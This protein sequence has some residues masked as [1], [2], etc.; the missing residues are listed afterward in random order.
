MYFWMDF[1]PPP[2]FIITKRGRMLQ[3]RSGSQIIC[4]GSAVQK[5]LHSLKQTHTCTCKRVTSI[6]V[7][8]EAEKWKCWWKIRLKVFPDETITL[9]SWSTIECTLLYSRVKW[10]IEVETPMF[11]SSEM[12]TWFLSEGR[13]IYLFVWGY[14]RVS[15]SSSSKEIKWADCDEVVISSATGHQLWF[16]L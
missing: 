3:L 9:I 2:T 5:T 12:F 6:W 4:C 10:S 16:V 8:K 14:F 15:T 13:L 7:K 1:P 11:V